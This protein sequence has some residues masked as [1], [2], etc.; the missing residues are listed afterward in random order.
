MELV[1]LQDVFFFVKLNIL[2]SY[3]CDFFF[4]YFDPFNPNKFQKLKLRKKTEKYIDVLNILK[5]LIHIL[6]IDFKLSM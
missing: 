6:K 2:I 4:I 5:I 3:K 1:E